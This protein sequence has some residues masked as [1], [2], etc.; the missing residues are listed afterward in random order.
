MAS[1]FKVDVGIRGIEYG[2]E[3]QNKEFIPLK[4]QVKLHSTFQSRSE[5]RKEK[6]R[7][8][9]KRLRNRARQAKN[10]EQ[11]EIKPEPRPVRVRE[12]ASTQSHTVQSAAIIET[13]G[14]MVVVE[15][16]ANPPRVVMVKDKGKSKMGFPYCD[17][18]PGENILET[19]QRTVLTEIG[20]DIAQHTKF[21]ATNIVTK[22]PIS[23]RD[24][25]TGAPKVHTVFV[26]KASV[27]DGV[28]ILWGPDQE[29]AFG[30]E[31]RDIDGYVSRGFVL[32]NHAN[33]WRCGRDFRI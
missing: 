1:N 25:S 15:I 8:N 26:F 14:A 22:I 24:E 32:F 5:R 9:L 33:G 16:R 18:L 31:Y 4:R 13:C 27:P 6:Q 30:V 17:A 11:P 20:P 28:K 21:A 3:Q 7:R 23:G 10:S 2:I 19:A 29:N 12:A